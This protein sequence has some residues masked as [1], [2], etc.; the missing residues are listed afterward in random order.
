VEDWEA[1]GYRAIGRWLVQFS[2][3]IGGMRTNLEKRLRRDGDD[4]AL[5]SVAFAGAQA[6]LI[7]DSFFGICRLIGDL[8]ESEANVANQ[9]QKEVVEHNQTRNKI[10]H[11]DWLIGREDEQGTIEAHLIRVYAKAPHRR[12][13]TYSAEDLDKLSD[14]L[15]QLGRMVWLFGQLALGLP[16]LPVNGASEVGIYRVGDVLIAENVPKGGKGGQVVIAGPR[17]SEIL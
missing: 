17:A 13:E 15:R 3:L 16:V 10:A 8:D 14:R 9:L 12:V 4:Q 7:L 6:K 1:D 11:G 5:V 2:R